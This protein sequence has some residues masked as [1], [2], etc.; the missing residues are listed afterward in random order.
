MHFIQ[1]NLNED[2]SVASLAKRVNLNQD[3]FSR[4]FFQATGGRPLE[5]V[6]SRRIERA[7]YLIATTNLSFSEIANQ[8]GFDNVHHFSRIFKN[9]TSVTPG[10][11]KKAN[12]LIYSE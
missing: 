2:L 9:I 10:K 6:H 3:Y 8:T 1:L 4:L 5:Y 7:Q 12:E 11:Y